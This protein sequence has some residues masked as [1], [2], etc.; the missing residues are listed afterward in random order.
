MLISPFPPFLAVFLEFFLTLL[1]VDLKKSGSSSSGMTIWDGAD[2]G[3]SVG[4]CGVAGVPASD[5]STVRS[6]FSGV[7]P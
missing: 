4:F 2:F 1:T 6:P 7:V 5:S 3:S